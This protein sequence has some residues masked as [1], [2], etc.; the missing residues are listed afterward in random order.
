[1]ETT[2]LV[3]KQIMTLLLSLLSNHKH[4]RMTIRSARAVL[5]TH[6]DACGTHD[7]THAGQGKGGGACRGYAGAHSEC[8]LKILM[9]PNVEDADDT[10]C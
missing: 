5:G 4:L 6:A 2:Q 9:T 3:I 8:E 10:Q 1:M 7:G